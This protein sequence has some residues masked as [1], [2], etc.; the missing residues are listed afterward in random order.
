M[1]R[2]I[3]IA[4]PSDDLRPYRARWRISELALFG[5]ALR[6]DFRPDSDIDLLAR[7]EAGV[8]WGLLDHAQMQ[9]ELAALARQD[10]LQEAVT[11][12]AWLVD[13]LTPH[14]AALEP[15]LRVVVQDYL[16]ALA[17]ERRVFISDYHPYLR[18]GDAFNQTP[19]G[20][21][22][23][24]A[25]WQVEPTF[26]WLVRYQGCRRARRVGTAAAQCQLYQACAVRNLLLWLSRVRRGL[27][28]RPAT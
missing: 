12:T 22:L 11:V 7:F 19:E 17:G 24:N 5:S 2:P 13:S 14:L 8:S 15:P 27:A 3:A 28:A 23:L 10:H 6:A 25:R 4:L 16:D 21:A 9:Q 1:Q 20:R 18:A 26:A